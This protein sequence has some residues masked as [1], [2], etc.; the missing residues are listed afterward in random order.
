MDER[1]LSEFEENPSKST[2][3]IALATG[4]SRST[5][6]NILQERTTFFIPLAA[7]T[8]LTL[9]AADYP[10]WVDIF[11]LF[12]QQSTTT[13]NFSANVLFTDEHWRI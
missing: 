2:H 3:S 11:W 10:L 9:N 7:D 12:F 1:I 13:P 6:L 4:V 5:I 8:A